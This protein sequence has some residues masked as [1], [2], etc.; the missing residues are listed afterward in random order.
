MLTHFLQC[1]QSKRN[2]YPSPSHSLFCLFC[3]LAVSSYCHAVFLMCVLLWKMC[4][5][6]NRRKDKNKNLPRYFFI[7]K[8]RK[9]DYQV[10]SHLSLFHLYFVMIQ[11]LHLSDRS[12]LWL[13]AASCVPAQDLSDR[14]GGRARQPCLFWRDTDST[15]RSGPG[16]I[17]MESVIQGLCLVDT[18]PKRLTAPWVHKLD[19]VG[20]QPLTFNPKCYF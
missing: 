13:G 6:M 1:M 7:S 19:S 15:S 11:G 3:A 16:G 2:L 4:K 9:S 5:K 12:A 17:M 14:V 20:I 10:F 8:Q 18:H